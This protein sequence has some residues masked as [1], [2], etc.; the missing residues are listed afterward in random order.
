MKIYRFA[1]FSVTILLLY[2]HLAYSSS[3]GNVKSKQPID[4]KSVLPKKIA[5]APQTVPIKKTSSAKKANNNK[6]EKITWKDVI[7]PIINFLSIVVA[8]LIVV[9]QL[10]RQHES[11][12]KLQCESFKSKTNLEVYENISGVVDRASSAVSSVGM[13]IFSLPMQITSNQNTNLYFDPE[14]F[15]IQ[16]HEMSNLVGDVLL[17]LEKYEITLPGFRIFRLALNVQSERMRVIF[18]STFNSMLPRMHI[19]QDNG[20]IYLDIP[21]G[22]IDSFRQFTNEYWEETSTMITYLS[23]LQIDAQNLLLSSIFEN[24]VPRRSPIDPNFLTIT[25]TPSEEARI[26]EFLR[27][28]FPQ[29]DVFNIILSEYQNR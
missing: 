18:N 14:S 19:N 3:N 12:L 9:Y 21:E 29:G 17:V 27:Q 22:D 24:I 1:F 4:S 23:D 6:Q 7:G 13:R 10:K 15:N 11:G 26:V 8:V 28:Q 20:A 5:P 2:S 25:S 16:H